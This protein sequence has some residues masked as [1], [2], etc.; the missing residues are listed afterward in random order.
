MTNISPCELYDL[1]HNRGLNAASGV[2]PKPMIVRDGIRTFEVA[3][4]PCGFAS[5]RI[6]PARG[7]LVSWLKSNKIGYKS[8]QGG[9]TIP[10]H[11]FGQSMELKEVYAREMVKAFQEHGLNVYFES[12]M[13]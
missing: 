1:A 6:M 7:K 9:W 10:C 5:V 2:T 12:R 8:Y 11:E 13:D 3:G 4:G